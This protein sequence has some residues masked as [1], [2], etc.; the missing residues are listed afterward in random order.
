MVPVLIH[1][2]VYCKLCQFSETSDM[3]IKKEPPSKFWD[4]LSI[5]CAKCICKE[6]TYG[7]YSSHYNYSG[8]RRPTSST[9]IKLGKLLRTPNYV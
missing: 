6:K 2:T 1:L 7:N 9:K 3:S 8:S 4:C 5:K